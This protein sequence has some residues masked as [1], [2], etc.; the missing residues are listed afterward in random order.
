MAAEFTIQQ[1]ADEVGLP[2]RTLRDWVKRGEVT[3]HKAIPP[4]RGVRIFR[5]ELDRLRLVVA[6]RAASYGEVRQETAGSGG[7]T[8]RAAAGGGE[9]RED[10]AAVE[11][12]T[13]RTQLAAANASLGALTEERDFLRDRLVESE[14]GEAELRVLLLNSQQ[15]LAIAEERLAL[16]AEVPQPDPPKRPWWSA[17]ESTPA[18]Q[19]KPWWK[20][21]G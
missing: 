21:W 7:E 9:V 11:V 8:V 20:L 10:A 6:E 17:P 19:S 18:G 13:L 5:E 16:P 3:T 14:K 12:A 2:S 15:A 4:A 1:A